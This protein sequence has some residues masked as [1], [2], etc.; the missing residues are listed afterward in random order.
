VTWH[1]ARADENS[2]KGEWPGRRKTEESVLYEF[3]SK[4]N[5]SKNYRF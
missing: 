5:L 3:D 1:K 2:E 4:V